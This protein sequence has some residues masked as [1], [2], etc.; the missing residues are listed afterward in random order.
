[1]HRYQSR[2][3]G[4]FAFLQSYFAITEQYAIP[5]HQQAHALAVQQ[6]T[7]Y[8]Q[9]DYALHHFTAQHANNPASSSS[10]NGTPAA[11]NPSQAIPKYTRQFFIPPGG[12]GFPGMNNRQNQNQ[13]PHPSTL[14]QSLQNGNHSMLATSSS[15]SKSYLTNASSDVD[16]PGDEG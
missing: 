8:Q 2:I 6:Q 14:S 11:R 16:P 9:L 12:G 4:S 10:S 3:Q 1:M 13:Q 7:L 15:S 5:F